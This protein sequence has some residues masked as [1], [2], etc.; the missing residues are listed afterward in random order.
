MIIAF[1]IFVSINALSPFIYCIALGFL[2][3]SGYINDEAAKKSLGP[4]YYSSLVLLYLT[5]LL[6]FMLLADA[7]RR[8][9]KSLKDNDKVE[10]NKKM[11]LVYFASLI[12]YFISSV[13]VLWLTAKSHYDLY[14]KR[15]IVGQIIVDSAK[16]IMSTIILVI[17]WRILT[18]LPPRNDREEQLSLFDTNTEYEASRKSGS[19]NEL[20]LKGMKETKENSEYS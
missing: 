11:M 10:V 5:M 9:Y 2:L 12:Y 6:S 17:Y 18:N 13:V 1:Y 4:L 8:I 15:T 3:K 16:Y 19:I 7:L 20:N 14:A